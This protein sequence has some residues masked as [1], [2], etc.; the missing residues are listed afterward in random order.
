MHWKCNC[1]FSVPLSLAAHVSRDVLGAFRLVALCT[2]AAINAYLLLDPKG[3]VLNVERRDGGMQKVELFGLQRFCTFTVWCWTLQGV[4]FAAALLST[5]AEHVF[6]DGV[7]SLAL[8]VIGRVDVRASLVAQVAALTFQVSFAL[9][10]LVSYVVTHALIPGGVRRGVPIANFF[11]FTGLTMHNANA[12]FMAVELALN[13]HAFRAPHCVFAILFGV[14]YVVFAQVYYLVAGY[15]FYFFLWPHK[16]WAALLHVGLLTAM[17]LFFFIGAG[18]ASALGTH[19]APALA[20][21]AA[22]T[23]MS[24]FLRMP[25]AAASGDKKQ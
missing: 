8:P 17:V 15:Y 10:F 16:A 9:A 21:L 20:A 11:H 13:G 18:M 19:R 2:V 3:I 22:L 7:L 6:Q 1:T 14:A 12:I 24:L 25:A 4:Y 23:Y 5:Y